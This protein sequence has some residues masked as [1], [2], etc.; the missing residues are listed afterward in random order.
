MMKKRSEPLNLFEM[1]PERVFQYEEG[2]DG[3]TVVLIPKFRH[4][5]MQWLQVR[6]R[7]KYFRIKLDA[8]GSHVWRLCDGK[9]TVAKIAESF[10][11]SFGDVPELVDRIS[12]FLR[13][14]ENQSLIKLK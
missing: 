10:Q 11:E 12:T 8:F 7:S 1:K 2:S 5:W 9:T 14:L 3:N 4:P 6:L 13:R